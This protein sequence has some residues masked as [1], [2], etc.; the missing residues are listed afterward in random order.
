MATILRASESHHDPHVAAFNFDDLAVQAGRHLAEARAEADAIIAQ[1]RAEADDVCRRATE[2]GRKAAAAEFEAAVAA[3]VAPAIAA[4]EQAAV[5]VQRAKQQWFSQWETDVVRLAAAI[6]AKVIRRELREQPEIT[7]SLVREALE[8]AAG[9]P[10]IHVHLNP[11]DY[12]T[13]GSQVRAIIAAMSAIGDA[14]VVSD[15]AVTAGGCRVETRFGV[16]DQQIESQLKRIEE[17]LEK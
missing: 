15:A 11:K 6:A 8:L 17:E 5:E 12:E 2:A 10:N 3:G 9:S 1:A 4:V 16:I 14:E 7:L 13:L